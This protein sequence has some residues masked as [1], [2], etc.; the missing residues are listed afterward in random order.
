MAKLVLDCVTVSKLGVGD[1]SYGQDPGEEVQGPRTRVSVF[2]V[3]R[4]VP[5]VVRG[6]AF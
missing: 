1:H 5:C 2:R 4:V 3:P 6:C